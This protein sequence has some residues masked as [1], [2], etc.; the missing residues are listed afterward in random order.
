MPPMPMANPDE[1][2]YALGQ[3][4]DHLLLTIGRFG[5]VPEFERRQID[6]E[7]DRLAKTDAGNSFILR[8]QMACL[9]G[10]EAEAE[11]QVSKAAL[12]GATA[13][14]VAAVRLFNLANYGRASDGLAHVRRELRAGH[15]GVSSMIPAAVGVGAV[16]TV[17]RVVDESVVGNQ[18]LA[19]PANESIV[20]A[21]KADAALKLA[22]RT[23]DEVAAVLDVAGEVQREWG[24]LWLDRQPQIIA[25]IGDESEDSAPGVHYHFRVDVTPR[26]AADMTGDVGWRLVGRDDLARSGISVAF[27]GSRLQALSA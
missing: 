23:E 24:L 12:C 3:R 26:E 15:A 19:A 25:L 18:V 13:D 22:G 6:R 9:D 5:A 27:I 4:I 2:A 11:R 21:K 8:S 16:S 7:I 20:L 1:L 14:R 10:Q 17:T